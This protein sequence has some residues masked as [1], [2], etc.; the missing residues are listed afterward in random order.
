MGKLLA[1]L[2]VIASLSLAGTALAAT[3][4]SHFANAIELYKKA[5]LD[6]PSPGSPGPWR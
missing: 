1:N 5:K 3:A 4:E 6:Q 2:L